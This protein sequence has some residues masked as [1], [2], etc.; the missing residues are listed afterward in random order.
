[1][2][3]AVAL[4]AEEKRRRSRVPRVALGDRF[5]DPS[6]VFAPAQTIVLHVVDQFEEEDA[7]EAVRELEDNSP[8]PKGSVDHR[9]DACM[10]QS[11]P[12][13]A[14]L[15]DLHEQRNFSRFILLSVLGLNTLHL[16]EVGAFQASVD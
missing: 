4:D 9:K 15:V 5:V 3:V 1:M 14:V 7:H 6:R 16:P 2:V 11:E 12:N 10:K 8:S 13:H